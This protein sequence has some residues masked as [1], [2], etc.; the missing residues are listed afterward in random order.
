MRKRYDN[1][2][3]V[4]LVELLL[5]GKTTGELSEDYDISRDL[6]RRWK[7]EYISKSG[8]LS[9]KNTLSVEEQEIRRLKKEIA[10][11][12]M[13]RDILKKAVSIFSKSDK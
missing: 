13:E 1:E 4:T 8:D 10:D 9:K 7:R 11:I 6:L 12:K 5:S 2:L 3:K